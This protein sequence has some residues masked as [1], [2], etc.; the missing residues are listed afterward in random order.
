[1]GRIK[2]SGL[3]T[4]TTS[5]SCSMDDEDYSSTDM[6]SRPLPWVVRVYFKSEN[7][8]K[9]TLCS[10]KSFTVNHKCNFFNVQILATIIDHY[11]LTTSKKCC[12]N[13]ESFR[14]IFDDEN[15]SQ[16]LFQGKKRQRSCVRKNFCAKMHPRND[17][18]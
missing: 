1:M 11:W 14:V 18:E 17:Q 5:Y 4:R 8:M 3:Q 12:L 7:S 2:R 10:G 6:I 9:G 13:K 16:W 15:K